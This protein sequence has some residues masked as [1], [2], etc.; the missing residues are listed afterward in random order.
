MLFKLFLNQ[1]LILFTMLAFLFFPFAQ[2]VCIA[3]QCT[4]R[5]R[6]NINDPGLVKTLSLPSVKDPK[7]SPT[8]K[9][10]TSLMFG[11]KDRGKSVYGAVVNCSGWF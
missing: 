4:V 6:V 8:T 11:E 9:T 5:N 1:L 7:L 3:F 10:F 2:S